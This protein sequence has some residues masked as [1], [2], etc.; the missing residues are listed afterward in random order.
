[1]A[2][3]SDQPSSPAIPPLNEKDM[4][5]ASLQEKEKNLLAKME[6]IKTYPREEQAAAAARTQAAL[7]GVRERIKTYA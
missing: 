6:Q 7:D 3:K 1:M 5:L 2:T 4:M